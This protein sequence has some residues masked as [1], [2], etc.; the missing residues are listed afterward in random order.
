[1]PC[2]CFWHSLRCWRSATGG[3][4]GDRRWA[5]A[6]VVLC[7]LAAWLHPLTLAAT[8][9]PFVY[10]GLHALWLSI[11][12]REALPLWRL[13]GIGI[14]TAIPLILLLGPPLLSD[15]ASLA[16]KAGV[17]QVTA[18][19][20]WRS[21]EL[22]AGSAFLPLVL[23]W[24]ALAG[25]GAILLARRDPGFAGYWLFVLVTATG[26]VTLTGGEWIHHPLVL[27]RYLLPLLPMMLFLV[28]V[29]VARGLQWLPPA[30][31]GLS[32][33]GLALML[34]LGGRCHPSTMPR[35]T[36]SRGT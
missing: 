19:T 22:F 10:H 5:A 24:L 27:A 21:L 23:V 4:S 26:L 18:T 20:F 1:M 14:V 32:T 6:Y 13:V 3:W 28:A 31:R 11:R 35:S 8:L 36:S 2:P 17:H 15:Y 30:W 12:E 16:G 33:V 34:Y 25:A 7:A 9:A 29:A